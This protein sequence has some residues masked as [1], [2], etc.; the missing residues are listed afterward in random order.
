MEQKYVCFL[1]NKCLISSLLNEIL[2][3]KKKTFINSLL[4]AFDAICFE[5]LL[6]IMQKTYKYIYIHV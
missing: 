2:Q 4:V 1:L 6:H 5:Y 3:L